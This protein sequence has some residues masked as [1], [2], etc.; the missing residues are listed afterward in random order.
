MHFARLLGLSCV[1][2]FAACS[3]VEA[4]WPFHHHGWHHSYYGGT[5]GRSLDYDRAYSRTYDT[6]RFYVVRDAS[7]LDRS[8]LFDRTIEDHAR[9]AARDEFERLESQRS[10]ARSYSP[11]GAISSTIL[12]SFLEQLA[13][14]LIQQWAGGP[15]I[16]PKPD[17]NKPAPVAADPELG[18]SAPAVSPSD[19][20]SQRSAQLAQDIAARKKQLQEELD[21]LESIQVPQLRNRPQ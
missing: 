9:S 17:C 19:E 13:R 1:L 6:S 7:L 5:S 16:A 8:S 18:R 15:G 3:P 14:Q 10:A 21:R 2:G 20:L 11:R 4:G 12:D